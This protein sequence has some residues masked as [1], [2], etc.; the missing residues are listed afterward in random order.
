MRMVTVSS[1][2]IAIHALTSGTSASRYQGSAVTVALVVPAASATPAPPGSQ[3]PRTKPPPTAAV[4]ARNSRRSISVVPAGLVFF[5][6]VFM[7]VSF[8]P[9]TLG[10]ESG[11][12]VNRLANA[13]V[14][15]APA[16]IGN[17]GV[18]VVVGRFG[19]LF[20]QGHAGQNHPGLAVAALGDVELFPRELDRMRAVGRQ[21]LD[22]GDRC[23]EGS[24]HRRDARAHGGAVH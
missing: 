17:V 22:G 1:G 12:P 4:V 20:Q 8:F 15:P 18:D 6:C 14:G 23:G 24:V 21:P 7:T 3:K 5:V 13:M 16:R 19:L 10:L 9:L 2:P 11:G